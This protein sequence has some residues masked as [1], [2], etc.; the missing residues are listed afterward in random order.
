MVGLE[1][2]EVGWEDVV[3]DCMKR[4]NSRRVR[5][6]SFEVKKTVE[7]ANVRQ[8][9]FQA[10]S[11]SSWANLGYLVAD[12]I[13]ER[14]KEEL[15]I[16]SQIHGIGVIELNASDPSKGSRTLIAAREKPDVDWDS[17]NRLAAANSDFRKFL[18]RLIK[19]FQTDDPDVTD[20]PEPTTDGSA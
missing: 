8:A 18:G 5:I 17:I 4:S 1:I 13:E 10:V 19:F 3:K 15:D 16:L 6:W 2:F 12:R 7:M 11:N 9:F 20:W 14:A